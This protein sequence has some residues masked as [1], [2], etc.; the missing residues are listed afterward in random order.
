MCG[1]KKL[2]LIY[3]LD[4]KLEVFSIGTSFGLGLADMCLLSAVDIAVIVDFHLHDI[5]PT[6]IHKNN[7]CTAIQ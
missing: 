5:F 4:I 1:L 2:L 6:E 7:I 3:L